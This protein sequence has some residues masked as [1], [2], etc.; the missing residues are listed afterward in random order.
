[1]DNRFEGK[2]CFKIGIGTATSV[3]RRQEVPDLDGL[4]LIKAQL[5]A[6]GWA[7]TATGWM[8]RTCEDCPKAVLSFGT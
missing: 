8:G 4:Q 1:M 6:E 2:R 3:D 5:M 7:K